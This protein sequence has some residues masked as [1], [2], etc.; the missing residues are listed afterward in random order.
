MI[1]YP[2]LIFFQSSPEQAWSAGTLLPDF[3]STQDNCNYVQE[4]NSCC[5]WDVLNGTKIA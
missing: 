5:G 3:V 4:N 1:G 2:G